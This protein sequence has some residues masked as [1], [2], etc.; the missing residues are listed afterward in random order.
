MRAIRPSSLYG[1]P[2]TSK[3]VFVHVPVRGRQ[4][5]P[6]RMQTPE[7]RESSSTALLAPRAGGRVA[8][9]PPVAS[10]PARQI[11]NMLDGRGWALILVLG[12]VVALSVALLV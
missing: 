11:Q 4:N 6:T 9:A 5:M 12:D 8:P 2:I 1:R 7:I 3:G 10:P